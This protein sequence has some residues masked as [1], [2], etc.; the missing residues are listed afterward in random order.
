[1]SLFQEPL[2]TAFNFLI[3]CTIQLYIL[4]KCGCFGGNSC[5][6]LKLEVVQILRTTVQ[7]FLK[8]KKLQN[9]RAEMVANK[10]SYYKMHWKKYWLK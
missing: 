8:R 5:F 9:M 3:K 1:M 7:K 4:C 10:V 6:T 2:K